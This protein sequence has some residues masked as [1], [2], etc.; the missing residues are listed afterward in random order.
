MG[1]DD[2][3]DVVSRRA[4]EFDAGAE[5][6]RDLDFRFATFLERKWLARRHLIAEKGHDFD[7]L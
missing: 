6:L 7:A 4:N 1:S 3:E 5:K 2:V